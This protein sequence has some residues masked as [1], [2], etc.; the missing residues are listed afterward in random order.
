M[1]IRIAPQKIVQKLNKQE[2]AEMVKGK[3]VVGVLIVLLLS[4][5]ASVRVDF[6][7]AAKILLV[8]LN[9]VLVF[10]SQW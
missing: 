7:W 2:T 1:I 5:A 6:Y 9:Q 4:V 3:L 10:V 8:P